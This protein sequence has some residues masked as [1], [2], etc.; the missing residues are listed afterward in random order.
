MLSGEYFLSESQAEW[1]AT[2]ENLPK[3]QTLKLDIKSP[4]NFIDDIKLNYLRPYLPQSGIVVEVGAGSGRLLTRIALENKNITPIGIDFES[5]RM[6]KDNINKFNLNGASIKADAYHIPLQY[7][8]AEAVISGG[9]L[10]HFNE[11]EIDKILQEMQRI[12][13]VGGL[14]YAEITPNKKSLCRPII[15]TEMGGYESTF[16]KQKWYEILKRDGYRNIKVT[17]GIVIPPNFFIWFKSGILLEITYK[18]KY[19]IEHMDNTFIS[20]VLGFS[21]YV[22]AEK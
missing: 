9:F 7:N 2:Y 16:N 5:T 17:S 18:L 4:E 13:K 14:F 8:L 15:L 20:D 21:Y 19:L 6:V 1:K 22:T 3:D 11:E 12:L 10:E